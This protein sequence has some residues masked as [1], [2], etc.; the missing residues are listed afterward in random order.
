MSAG[1]RLG[2]HGRSERVHVLPTRFKMMKKFV[3]LMTTWLYLRRRDAWKVKLPADG[4]FLFTGLSAI[5]S[6]HPGGNT[7]FL[8]ASRPI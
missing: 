6:P 5:L 8:P 1:A 4:T 3:M 7:R 2:P